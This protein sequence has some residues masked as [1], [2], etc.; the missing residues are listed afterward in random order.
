MPDVVVVSEDVRVTVRMKE[1]KESL[2]REEIRLV[3]A[4]LGPLM[5]SLLEII[6]EE[7]ES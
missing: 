6:T 5:Q 4:H 2:S 3:R 1:G 7:E